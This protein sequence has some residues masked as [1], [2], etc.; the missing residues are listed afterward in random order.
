MKLTLCPIIAVFLNC[1]VAFGASN[2]P[3]FDSL[4][5]FEETKMVAVDHKSAERLKVIRAAAQT[6]GLQSG[7]YYASTEVRKNLETIGDR[8]DG[9]YD[10]SRLGLVS[11]HKGVY[12]INPVIVEIEKQISMSPDARSFIVRD[13][14]YEIVK[15]PYLSLSAPSWRTYLTFD[16]EPPQIPED[17]IRPT[18]PDEKAAW[19]EEMHKGYSMGVRQVED[20]AILRFKRLTRDILGMT[21]YPMLRDRKLVSDVKIAEAYYPVSG[22]GN[23]M[24]IRE[25]RVSIDVNP[26]LNTNRWDWQVIP[27]LS[28]ISD[29]FPEDGDFEGWIRVN[30]GK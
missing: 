14:V 9:I 16:V 4:L 21:L 11:L 2:D 30:T 20:L 27:R 19:K 1:S 10:F 29:L 28:D 3:L 26:Q 15:D 23:K 6:I 17:M 7:S 25:S 12:V 24:N 22:G 5:Q 8:L 18:T 13:Q